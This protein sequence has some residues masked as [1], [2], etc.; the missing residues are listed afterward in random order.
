MYNTFFERTKNDNCIEYSFWYFQMKYDSVAREVS[1]SSF[2]YVRVGFP[3][4]NLA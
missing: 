2:F 4:T 3:L 1:R